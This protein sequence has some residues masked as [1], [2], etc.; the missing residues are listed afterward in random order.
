VETVVTTA[1]VDPDLLSINTI[2]GLCIDAV[3]KAN[4]G[5]PGTPLDIAPVAYTLWQRFL[6]FD[7]SDPIWPNRDR[8]V[9]SEGHASALLWSLLHL[10]KV[11]AV[12]PAYEILG[13][14]AVT[15]ADLETFRQLNSK[16]PGHPEY[17]W[18]SGVE[19]TTGPLGQGVATSVGMAIGSKW[20]AARYN[21][22]DFELFD[23]DVYALAGDGCMMEGISSEA[24]SLAAHLGLS[25]LCWIYDSN[26]VTIEGHTDITFTEDV[27]ARFV[28]YGWN[29][30]TVA[31]ANDLDAVARAFHVF[32]A[33]S[34]RPTL[35]LVHSHIGYG[36]PV[37][38]SP[39]AHGE[40]LGAEG[41]RST[42]QF[43]GMPPDAEFFVPDTVYEHFERGIG[44][45]GLTARRAWELMFT[46]YRR[47]YP[48]LADEIE[49]MQR[50]EL[51]MDWES[52][53]P[54]FPPDSKGLASR[55][56][57]GQVLNDL[58]GAVPWVLGGSADLSPSTKTNLTFDGAGDFQADGR[59]GR[60]L[61]FG[62]REHASAAICNGLAL[63]KLRPYWSGFLIFSDYAKGAIRLS[64]LM[65]IPVVHVF[66]HDSIGVG[67]DGPTH[68]PVEQLASL[69]AIPGMLVFRPSDANEVVETWRFVAA[70]HREPAVIV[71]SR[72]ALPTFD[73]S[74]VAPAA[75][76]EKGAYVLIDAADGTPDVILMGTGSEVQLVMAA[77]EEL[78]GEGIDARVVSMPCWELFDRQPREYRE[79]V[80]PPS[81]R[82]RVAV[83]Q[84]STLGWD[85]YVG[86][87]GAVIGM[88]TF[89]ASAPLK[90]LLTKFGFTPDRV[91]DVARRCVT[92]ARE[93]VTKESVTK[94][95][96]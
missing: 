18:T 48:E 25:N 54:T 16:C 90:E 86:D 60:N 40:P 57:S 3:E 88:H 12:D 66:T 83:E 56:S 39:K 15:L 80:L 51:P 44:A 70:L 36:S 87:G 61:H 10:A 49:R 21:R 62:I 37:E 89:G 2:R 33:E 11:M 55:D 1:D 29:L 74:V 20:L 75:G 79:Q 63:T 35:V 13:Q 59:S 78:L 9:L 19:T 32:K 8:F 91:A 73:R 7:P 6:R 42:K 95:S 4:S 76:V 68:Q 72:Q 52:A 38:D 30:T 17:R 22:P 96:L 45:A 67:E 94:E 31:D 23:F 5:H 64:A 65:E 69:R 92:A 43:L 46:E 53:L 71:L 93:S 41:V 14:P 84:A 27:A 77:R 24:A 28:A 85:R 82:A 81:V 50:R 47:A 34:E 58:A 26:R